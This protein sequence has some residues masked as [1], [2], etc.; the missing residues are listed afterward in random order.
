MIG[1]VVKEKKDF[2]VRMG[3]LLTLAYRLIRNVVFS[4]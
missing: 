4:A 2:S 1:G 3:M